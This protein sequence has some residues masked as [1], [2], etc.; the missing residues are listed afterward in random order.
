MSQPSTSSGGSPAEPLPA[1][2]P[3]PHRCNARVEDFV[4]VGWAGGGA[5][6]V[7]NQR[8]GWG[9]L[10][11]AAAAAA[12]GAAA[13]PP[14]S[15]HSCLSSQA[16]TALPPP[17]Q[18]LDWLARLPAAACRRTLSALAL[19]PTARCPT[20]PLS[21]CATLPPGDCHVGLLRQDRARL[22]PHAAVLQERAGVRR[23]LGWPFS[24]SLSRCCRRRAPAATFSP[25]RPH[26][27]PCR[28]PSSKR[29]V[30]GRSPASRTW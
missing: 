23:R 10:V 2:M 13:V 19:D 24:L 26:P 28:L 12:A 11:Q 16:M 3:K 21:A 1:K 5:R 17:A 6:G 14:A 9:A 8:Q 20:A 27:P 7:L 22:A 4:Q 30:A 18:L 29:A 25:P 15:P